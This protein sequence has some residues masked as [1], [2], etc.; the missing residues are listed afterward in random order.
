MNYVLVVACALSIPVTA[1]TKATYR[2][3]DVDEPENSSPISFLRVDD[4]QVSISPTF[5]MATVTN[6]IFM[7]QTKTV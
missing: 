6:T 2:R 1:L 5:F 7:M 3:L 4:S